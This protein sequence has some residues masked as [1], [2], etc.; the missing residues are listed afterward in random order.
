MG[1]DT[2]PEIVEL[3][4]DDEDDA[5]DAGDSAVPPAPYDTEPPA[6]SD[7]KDWREEFGIDDSDAE[8][9]QGDDE[10]AND[11]EDDDERA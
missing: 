11:D 9:G 6:Q 1:G 10:G 3:T 8:A 5:V 7:A 4:G 2:A